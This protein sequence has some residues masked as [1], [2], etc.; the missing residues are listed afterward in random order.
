MK[1]MSLILSLL[2]AGSAFAQAQADSSSAKHLFACSIANGTEAP[3]VNLSLSLIQDADA[4][5]LVVD[6]NDKGTE[7]RMFAQGSKG[8]VES[9]ITQGALVFLLFEES[10]EQD[11]GVVRNAGLIVLQKAD[12]TSFS[13]LLSARGNL[14]PL[15]CA[16]N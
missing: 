13:G 6:V 3:A 10:L 8:E 12:A 11:A 7:F 2:V 14:Y 16:M 15:T 9:G 5:F 4:D 1:C